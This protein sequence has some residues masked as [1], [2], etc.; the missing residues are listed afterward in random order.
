MVEEENGSCGAVV[1]AGVVD[2]CGGGGVVGASFRFFACYGSSTSSLLR[3]AAAL[4]F[5][6]INRV[7]VLGAEEVMI[8]AS[9]KINPDNIERWMN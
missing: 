4:R 1:V 7:I 3:L 2:R 9:N 5:R 6:S 8:T